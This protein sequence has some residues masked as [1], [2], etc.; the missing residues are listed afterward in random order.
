VTAASIQIE[1]ADVLRRNLRKVYKDLPKGMKLIHQEIAGPVAGLA[2]S[3]A[4]KQSGKMA[5]SIRVKATITKAQITAGTGLPY[6]GVQHW[7]WAG[8]SIAPNLFLTEAIGERQAETLVLYEKK[9]G[10]WIDAV[11]DDTH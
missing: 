8:H 3:K 4:R 10:D 1:G 2:R 11:W 9:L 6:A 7:G 5:G